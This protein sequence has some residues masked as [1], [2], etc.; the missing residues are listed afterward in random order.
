MSVHLYTKGCEK[1][2][3]LNNGHAFKSRARAHSHSLRVTLL[4]K[5]RGLRQ[6]FRPDR[7]R[8]P[9]NTLAQLLS[10]PLPGDCRLV[11]LSR[12]VPRGQSEADGVWP[13]KEL[14][15]HEPF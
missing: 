1:E 2:G 3:L 4:A 8:F 6:L 9:R 10:T 15:L 11:W 7:P 12:A 14:L 5:K 13:H